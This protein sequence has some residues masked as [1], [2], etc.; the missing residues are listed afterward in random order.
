[1]LDKDYWEKLCVPYQEIEQEKK[2]YLS[3]AKNTLSRIPD[4]HLETLNN[5]FFNANPHEN[6]DKFID[7][8]LKSSNS[9]DFLRIL[10]FY[11]GKRSILEE[12][13]HK[14]LF[15]PILTEP[16]FRINF[17]PILKVYRNDKQHLIDALL[18]CEY[19]KKKRGR[20]IV[21]EPTLG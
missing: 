1:M 14:P 5:F 17:Y 11:R 20:K 7:N 21:V 19:K 12:Y 2:K 3:K 16:D 6:K 13:F 18:Y 9:T 10:Y 8:I 15:T 4:S